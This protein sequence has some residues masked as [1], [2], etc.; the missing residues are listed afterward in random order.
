MGDDTSFLFIDTPIGPGEKQHAELKSVLDWSNRVKVMSESV[1]Y[2]DFYN[3]F[4]KNTNELE[5]Q[6]ERA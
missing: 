1:R 5:C 2:L 3:E 6:L 4:M